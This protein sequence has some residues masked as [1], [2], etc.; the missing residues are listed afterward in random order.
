MKHFIALVLVISISVL[1]ACVASAAEPPTAAAL[2]AGC[3]NVS[4]PFI[5]TICAPPTPGRHPAMLLLGGSEGGNSTMPKIAPLFAARG[6]VA[7]TVA[8]FGLPGLPKYLV[9]VPV[10]IVGRALRAVAARRDVNPAEIGIFG[11]SKGGELALLAA[12]IYPQIKAVV[13]D[14][15][16]PVA[17]MGLG[18]NDTPSGCSWS[19]RGKPLPCV[20]VSAAAAAAIGAQ[21]AS[22]HT[23]R[24]RV[25]YDLSLDADPTQ[26]RAAF[27]PLQRIHG[28]V[29]CLAGGDDEMWNSPRQCAMA[30]SYLKAHHHRFA[31]R[32]VTYPDAGHTFLWAMRGPKS[33]VTEFPIGGGVM[34]DF[35]GT[36]AGDVAASK[37]AWKTIWAFLAHAL[38]GGR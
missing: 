31:D 12:S 26:V 38:T 25:L 18:V 15:P 23:V 33:A 2:P 32:A 9:N 10:E 5:G 28:P 4:A 20:P 36:P 14:V 16:S 22:G 30:M 37:R 35:G 11:G 17:F 8:Y 27:F 21:F 24:L 6:Y 3:T 13:A 19:Y 1:A 7:V 34:M 29:L